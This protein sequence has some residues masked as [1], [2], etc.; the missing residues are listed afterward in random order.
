[1]TTVHG[2]IVTPDRIVNGGVTFER[3]T[4]THAG[5]SEATAAKDY[6]FGDALVLPGF[7]DVHMHGLGEN[8]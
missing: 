5:D 1:M 8:N 4:I 7:I 2:R 6:D 3:G